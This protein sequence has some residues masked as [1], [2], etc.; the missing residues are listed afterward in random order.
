MYLLIYIYITDQ[1]C[2]GN[3]VIV[4]DANMHVR[5]VFDERSGRPVMASLYC[6]PDY[7]LYKGN[8]ANLVVSTTI[9][10]KQTQWM[11]DPTN[12]ICFHLTLKPVA[13]GPP[14][15]QGCLLCF[16]TFTVKKRDSNSGNQVPEL[17]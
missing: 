14:G 6:K 13:A 7:L 12:F 9:E 15:P 17:R 11:P 16:N 10:C 3:L 4:K 1:T 8:E 2:T 5:Y